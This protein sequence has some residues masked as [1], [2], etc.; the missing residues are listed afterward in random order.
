VV[1]KRQNIPRPENDM[2]KIRAAFR[3]SD[4]CTLFDSD[5]GQLE[6]RIAASWSGD[7]DMIRPILEGRDAHCWT[8]HKM[9]H[10]P[11][12]EL[13]AAYDA[14]EAKLA[15]TPRQKDLTLLR[16]RSKTT[17][18]G[19]LYGK[20]KYGLATE[21]GISVEEA[22]KIILSYFNGYPLL[23]SGYEENIQFGERNGFVTTRLGRR[24]VIPQLYMKKVKRSIYNEGVRAANNFCIQGE[25]GEIAKGAQIR[26]YLDDSIWDAGVRQVLQVHDEIIAEGPKHLQNDPEFKSLWEHYLMHPYEHFDMTSPVPLVASMGSGDNWLEAK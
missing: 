14:K 24:R 4:G 19:I 21:L 11:Y 3:A 5:F 1:T 8:A 15:L 22:D 17:G 13:K 25:A 26:I 16:T 18:F 7:P 9:Y 10:E 23:K 6:M 20:S 2:A 12:E